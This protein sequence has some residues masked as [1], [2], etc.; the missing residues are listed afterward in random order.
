MND[1]SS[2]YKNSLLLELIRYIQL[3]RNDWDMT[4]EFDLALYSIWYL[5]NPLELSSRDK[6]VLEFPREVT[7]PDGSYISRCN[8][9]SHAHHNE[10]LHPSVNDLIIYKTMPERFSSHFITERFNIVKIDPCRPYRSYFN[11]RKPDKNGILS[12]TIG[13]D[14]NI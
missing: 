1:S 12:Y 11:L 9:T 5:L 10:P 8:F 7:D 2:K 6:L 13:E 14:E 3:E 4:N